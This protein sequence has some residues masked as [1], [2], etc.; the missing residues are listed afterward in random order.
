MLIIPIFIPH[1][2]C[3]HDCC[4]CDQK[5]ISGQKNPPDEAEVIKIVESYLDIT[6]NYETV[7]IAFFGG[8]FTAMDRSLMIELLTAANEFIG[9]GMFSSIRISTVSLIPTSSSAEA[10]SMTTA[11]FIIL[12]K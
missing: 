5:K 3:P 7:Q 8:S 12:S 10:S 1:A 2:G 6:S 4:F 9:D 11:V